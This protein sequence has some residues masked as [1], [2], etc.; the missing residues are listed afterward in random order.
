MQTMMQKSGHEAPLAVGWAFWPAP[1]ALLASAVLFGLLVRSRYLPLLVDLGLACLA[2][3]AVV[4][5]VAA[6]VHPGAATALA[7]ALLGFGAGATVSPGL[8]LTGF[9]VPS[10]LLGRAFALVQLLRSQATFAVAPLLLASASWE[11]GVTT[12]LCLAVL[13]LLAAVLVPALSGAR[14]RTPDLEAWLDRGERAMVSPTTVVH[15]R[16][17]HDEEAEPLVPRRRR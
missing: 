10:K 2:S 6:P 15:V 5:L 17:S 12:A 1:V 14:L 3:G 16:R 4:L 13:G 7:A 8:F 11:A 9:G